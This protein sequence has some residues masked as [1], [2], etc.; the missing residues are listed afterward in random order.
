MVPVETI[1]EVGAGG[2]FDIFDTFVRTCVNATMHPT[3]HNNK[4]NQKQS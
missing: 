1:S 4:R 3:Q 2:I